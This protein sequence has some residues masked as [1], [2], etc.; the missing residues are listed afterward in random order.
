VYTPLVRDLLKDWKADPQQY[1]GLFGSEYWQFALL[2]KNIERNLNP[3]DWEGREMEIFKNMLFL[4]QLVDLKKLGVYGHYGFTH[5]L[6]APVNDFL[7]LAGLLNKHPRFQGVVYS[8]LGLL[9]DCEVLW[10]RKYNKEGQYIGYKATSW[11]DGDNLF[12]KQAGL[13]V[14]RK[15]AAAQPLTLFRLDQAESPFTKEMMFVNASRG[16]RLWRLEEGRFTLDYIQ[17][18]ILIQNSTANTPIEELD[19]SGD[20]NI[21]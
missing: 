15:I 21:R 3:D 5:L 20:Q 13:R 7:P 8:Y 18:I 2:M 10:N 16:K 1:R 14:L 19:Y 12:E 9:A 6:Q 11:Q 17:A 4:D